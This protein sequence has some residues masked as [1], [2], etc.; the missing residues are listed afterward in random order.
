[1]NGIE[2]IV[3]EAGVF[4]Y[5]FADTEEIVFSQDVRDMCA[6]NTCRGYGKTWSCPPGIGTLAE[7]RERLQAYKR[8]LL[9]SVK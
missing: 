2:A 4:E 6:A 8:M 1:M 7:C 3:K 5:G 9:F